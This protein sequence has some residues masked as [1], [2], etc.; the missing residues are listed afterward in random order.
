MSSMM[1]PLSP[2]QPEGHCHWSRLSYPP[3]LSSL[4]R[5]AARLAAAFM[6]NALNKVFICI[7]QKCKKSEAAADRQTDREQES[8]R[9]REEQCVG[10]RDTSYAIC[11][12]FCYELHRLR[13]Y[14]TFTYSTRNRAEQMA[15]CMIAHSTDTFIL[16]YIQIP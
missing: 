2:G 5:R 3:P 9:V 4:R 12:V 6:H 13:D 8:E 15:G 14:K 11:L 1:A 10:K 7:T 16:K